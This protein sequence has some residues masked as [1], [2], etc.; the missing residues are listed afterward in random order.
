MPTTYH[1]CPSLVA[2]IIVS[3]GTVVSGRCDHGAVAS[4]GRAAERVL[5]VQGGQNDI[6]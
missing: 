3:H 4:L 2:F 1:F 5:G 6:G